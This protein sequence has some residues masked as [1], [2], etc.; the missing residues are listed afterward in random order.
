MSKHFVQLFAGSMA[1]IIFLVFFS[2]L[3]CIVLLAGA[4][5]FPLLF[6]IFY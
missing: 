5:S 2:S 4:V 6:S 1:V 3:L